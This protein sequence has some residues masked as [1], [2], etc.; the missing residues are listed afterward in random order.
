MYINNHYIQD[1]KKTSHVP[2]QTF[3]DSFSA[4]AYMKDMKSTDMQSGSFRQSKETVPAIVE[5]ENVK[6]CAESNHNKRFLGLDFEDL[7]L[8]AL[9]LLYIGDDDKRDDKVIPVIL[10]VLLF[11]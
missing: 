3:G 11:I 2:V 6:H 1:D 4:D 5:E 9:L 8:I 10:S 7:L